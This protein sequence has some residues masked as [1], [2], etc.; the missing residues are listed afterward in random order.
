MCMC[1]AHSFTNLRSICRW[2]TNWM[3][4]DR[5]I[6]QLCTSLCSLAFAYTLAW[7]V[8]VHTNARQTH[9]DFVAYKCKLKKI[10]NLIINTF[11]CAWIFYVRAFVWFGVMWCAVMPCDVVV[12]CITIYCSLSRIFCLIFASFV[13]LC[14]PICLSVCVF[15]R[16]FSFPSSFLF[17]F[18][19]FISN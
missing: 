5:L 17:S 13:C 9:I 6:L 14:M 16:L 19:S 2:N 1:V 18:F 12:G 4:M 3:L 7:Q 8:H 10:I 11:A 15:V